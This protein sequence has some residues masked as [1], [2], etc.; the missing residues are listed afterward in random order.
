MDLS[1]QLEKGEQKMEKIPFED[2]HDV[3][4]I[5]YRLAPIDVG[6]DLRVQDMLVLVDPE[7]DPLRVSYEDNDGERYVIE[8]PQAEVLEYLREAG[9]CFKT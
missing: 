7:D 3:R 1:V 8:G 6:F 4:S 9:Y 5:R 2:A